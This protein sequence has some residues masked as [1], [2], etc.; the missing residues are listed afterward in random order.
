MQC[1]CTRSFGPVATHS[2]TTSVAPWHLRGMPPGQRTSTS[3]LPP[4]LACAS[5]NL[6]LTTASFL[7]SHLW[8]E[9]L[10]LQFDS[11]LSLALLIDQHLSALRM[12]ADTLRQS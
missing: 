5:C 8:L 6:L 9:V 11:K 7:C 4:R 10:R 3:A 2:T 12:P 1:H